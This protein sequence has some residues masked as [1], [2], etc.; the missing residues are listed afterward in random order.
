LSQSKFHISVSGTGVPKRCKN[1]WLCLKS[2]SVIVDTEEVK[3]VEKDWKERE[4][5][6]GKENSE[7][8]ICI[9]NF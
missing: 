7:N 8:L 2:V 3:R 6:D 9:D 5:L 4:I 1:L